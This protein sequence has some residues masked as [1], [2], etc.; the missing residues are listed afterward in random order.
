MRIG[1]IR[2][3]IAVTITAAALSAAA[4][5]ALTGHVAGAGHTADA[6]RAAILT[7]AGSP[8]WRVVK[9]LP[10]GVHGYVVTA[11]GP[12][13]EWAFGGNGTGKPSAWENRGAGWSQV[14]FPGTAGEEVTA[15]GASSS[16]NVWVFTDHVGDEGG[17][18]GAM[19]WNGR[20]WS[21]VGL[22][23][24][25]QI[26]SVA[27]LSPTD[28]WVFGAPM[29]WHWNGKG[30]WEVS[31]TGGG[32][33][34][35]GGSA[36]SADDAWVYGG[37]DGAAEAPGADV[38]HWNGRSWKNTSLARLL[39]VSRLGPG[40]VTAI[41]EQS[42]DSVY[43][44]G[45]ASVYVSTSNPAGADLILTHWNG[46]TW[47]RVAQDPGLS[48]TSGTI[49]G[50]GRGGLWLADVI[51]LHGRALLHYAV[52]RQGSDGKLTTVSMPST[53]VQVGSVAQIPGTGAALAGGYAVPRQGGTPADFLLQYG[54]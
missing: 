24:I 42:P 5:T 12:G 13:S 6:A 1:R 31:A 49:A 22:W 45:S 9:D 16:S 23:Y 29:A 8:S 10:G 32:P 34:V 28:V 14:P 52:S 44:L 35:D 50:D 38:A 46:S 33:L 39:T 27:V 41:Y 43:A 20:A 2:T 7:E 40:D 51:T 30:W 25:G 37:I 47:S 15:A 36:R 26:D 19:R 17:G 3:A 18:V 53:A 21:S 48:S 4:V 54:S 11:A